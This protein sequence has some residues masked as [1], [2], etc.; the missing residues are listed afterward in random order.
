MRIRTWP[1]CKAA[2][3]PDASLIHKP[4]FAISTGRPSSMFIFFFVERRAA[5]RS[6]DSLN[7]EL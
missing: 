3:V 5:Y 1:P 4:I 7:N 6:R 2:D